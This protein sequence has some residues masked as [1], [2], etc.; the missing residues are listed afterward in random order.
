MKIT[1][2][3]DSSKELPSIQALL[4]TLMKYGASDLHLKAGRPPLLRISG[5]LFPTKLPKLTS[6]SVKRLCFSLMNEKQ[7]HRLEEDLHIDFSYGLKG[8]ARFRANIFYQRGTLSGTIRMIPLAIPSLKSLELPNVVADLCMKERGLLLVTGAT[9]SGKSTTLAAMINHMNEHRRSH[10]VTLEDP[11]EF[12]YHD[13]RSSVSQREIGTD[14]HDLKEALRAALRQD[15]DVIVMGEMR[16]AETIATAVSAAETGHL[17]LSTLHTTDAS[18]SL[19]RIIDALPEKSQN[20]I[21][22][23]LASSLVGILSQRLVEKQTGNGRALAMEI[24]LNSPTI[25]RLII[26]HKLK[27][28]PNAIKSSKDYYK[29]QTMNQALAKLVQTN[30]ISAAEAYRNSTNPDELKLDLSGFST[31][32]DGAVKQAPE[33]LM[34]NQGERVDTDSGIDLDRSFEDSLKNNGSHEGS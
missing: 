4:K 8:V 24:M 34:Q 2:D 27:E 26:E 1:V 3:H 28:I 13:V 21:R 31:Q 32:E 30:Q 17:V 14:T 12:I 25:Q 29:M 6:E 5:K 23:Q 7:I 11:I 15:P 19:D 20:Q 22:L 10:I 16:D 9:G 33:S 18:N